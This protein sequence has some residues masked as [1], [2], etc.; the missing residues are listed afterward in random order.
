MPWDEEE[1]VHRG[2]SFYWCDDIF[3][4]LQWKWEKSRYGRAIVPAFQVQ[5]LLCLNPFHTTRKGS[6]KKQASVS[7][8]EDLFAFVK[9]GTRPLKRECKEC[10][11]IMFINYRKHLFSG[12]EP[13]PNRQ[14]LIKNKYPSILTGKK[15]QELA[16]RVARESLGGK[17]Y[18][19]VQFRT[20]KA[21]ALLRRHAVFTNSNEAVERFEGWLTTCTESLVKEAKT[22]AAEM[23]ENVGFF[24]ASDMLNSGWKGGDIG[25]PEIE[26]MLN[27]SVSYF[28]RELPDLAWFE[29]DKYDVKQDVMGISAVVDAGVM[30]FSDAFVYALPSSFGVW[31]DEQRGRHNRPKAKVVDC[32]I[33]EF[34]EAEQW[35]KERRL[36]GR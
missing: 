2:R 6:V 5:R 23:G 27:T 8:F 25:S 17:K 34:D 30:Y 12:I 29:P 16:K 11:S 7:L 36:R 9:A 22:Q 35:A 32:M 1:H 15:Q 3:D 14:K 18:V 24:L 20:G 26:A 31:V 19:G 28:K 10:I 21:S 4:Q 33:P 13:T